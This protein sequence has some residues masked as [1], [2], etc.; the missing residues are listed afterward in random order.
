MLYTCSFMVKTDV[1]EHQ[2]QYM[3]LQ[4]NQLYTYYRLR[5]RNPARYIVCLNEML[6]YRKHN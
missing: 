3:I 5:T 1:I 4:N 2:T 6:S